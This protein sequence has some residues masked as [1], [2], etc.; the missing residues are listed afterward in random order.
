M[1]VQLTPDLV[2]LAADTVTVE[3]Y[4]TTDEYG[5]KSYSAPADYRVRAIGRS[6]VVYGPDGLERLSGATIVF[7]GEYDFSVYDRYTL[8]L[9]FSTDI[10]DPNN[11]EARQ[12]VCLSVDRETDENGPHH[13]T[14]YFAV[15][16]LRGY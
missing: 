15:S 2:A 14:V 5:T 7:F 6:K 16:R 4:L 11:L 10:R 13:T 12:P 1:A 9:R 3:K 8:P